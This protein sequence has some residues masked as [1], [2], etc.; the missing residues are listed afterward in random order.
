M[1]NLFFEALTKAKQE[2]RKSSARSA[3]PLLKIASMVV[4]LLMVSLNVWGYNIP[5]SHPTL[6]G[7]T[8]KAG[9]PTTVDSDASESTGSVTL[10]Y[11]ISS[12]YDPTD[13]TITWSTASR[14]NMTYGYN[15]ER[16]TDTEYSL[17]LY[18]SSGKWGSGT[19]TKFVNVY[20]SL[21]LLGA[22]EIDY[23][24]SGCT[25]SVE[26]PA[27]ALPGATV[28]MTVTPGDGCELS[29]IYALDGDADEITVT[30]SGT[31]W[32]FTMPNSEVTIEVQFTA[33]ASTH[34]ITYNH[35]KASCAQDGSGSWPADVSS[36]ADGASYN[37][38]PTDIE[39][40]GVD[41]YT[42][43]GW[44]T[45]SSTYVHGTS[46]LYTT[47]IAS[48]TSDMTLYPVFSSGSSTGSSTTFSRI[49]KTDV[50]AGY[51]IIS[52]GQNGDNVVGGTLTNNKLSNISITGGTGSSIPATDRLAMWQFEASG[53]SGNITYWTIKNR[54]TGQY[55]ALSHSGSTI[56]Q[57]KIA[58]QAAVDNYAKWTISQFNA[59]YHIISAADA[60]YYLRLNNG[61]WDAHSGGD[62]QPKFLYKYATDPGAASTTY[63]IT[64]EC[65]TYTLTYN[66]NGATSGSVP[67]V[68]TEYAA[69]TSV[70]VLGN[71]G[72]LTKT[73]YDFNGWKA[74]NAS[75][76]TAYAAGSSI[77]MSANHTLYAQWLAHTI[78]LTL[79]ANNGGATSDGSASVKYDA[80][81]LD[82]SPTL[83]SEPTG[84]TILGYYAAADGDKKV[85]NA[86][87][88]FAGSAV[89]DYI[90][91]S[92]WSRDVTPTELYA[93]W[94][95]NSYT[96]VFHKNDASA[97]GT[98]SD[99]VFTYGVAQSLTANNFELEEHSFEGWATTSDGEVVYGDEETVN[100]L[101]ATDGAT[102]DLY[103]VWSNKIYADYK[104]TCSDLSLDNAALNKVVWITT[105]AGQV[106]R[107]ANPVF[108]ISG[109]GLKPGAAITFTLG[110]NSANNTSD[111][112]SFRTK[113]YSSIAAHA[114][115]GALA[116]TE[117]YAFYNPTATTDGLDL[118][119]VG[120]QIVA[121]AAGGTSGG[122]KYMELTSTLANVAIN[123]RHLPSRFVIAAR[124]GKT[125]YAL[126]ANLT[127][128]ENP[129]PVM[130]GV[131]NSSAPTIAY[132][133]A[134]NAYDLYA[135][136]GTG[137]ANWKTNGHYINFGMPNN[138][139]L[140][141]AALWANNAKN[142]TNIGK[143]GDAVATSAAL[144]SNYFWL[145]EQTNNSASTIGEVKYQISNPNNSSPL[146]LNRGH[147][148]WGLY[149][150]TV[151]E[152]HLLSIQE[153]QPLTLDVME[154]G[155]NEM[156]V[157]YTG[158]GTL[159]KV[160]IGDEEEDGASMSDIAGD[161]KRI[162]G[163]NSMAAGAGGKQCQ[164]M[165]IQITESEVLKQKILQIPFIVTGQDV[166]TDNLRTWTDGATATEQDSITYNMEIVVRP[167]AKLTTNSGAG[168]FGKLSVYPGGAADISNAIRLAHFTM[169]GG[170]SWLG[171]EFAM[172]H[173]KVTGNVTGTGN[174]VNYDYYIDATKYYDLALPKTMT[175]G[176]VT[177]D[178]GY[179]NFTFWVKEYDGA[180]RA[181][182]GK[183]W[184]W[185][186][187]DR[188]A[189]LW[190]INAG[191][192]YLV[193]ATPRYGRPYLVMHF[194]MPLT[195][196]ADESS[197]DPVSV[198]AYG[199]TGGSLNPGVSANNAGWNF[200]AN[201]F[202]TSYMKDAD[203]VD[204]EGVAISG[205]IKT[206][207]LVPEEKDGKPTGK[208]VW[209]ETGGKKI[210]YVTTYDYSTEKYTQHA[211]SSTVLEP[212]TGFFI[213]VAE[214]CYVKFDPNERQNNIIARRQKSN[215]PDDM[216]V[217]ITASIGEQSDETIIL[218]CD[219]L[220][221]DNALEFPDESSKIMNAGQLNFYTFAGTNTMYANGMT[222]AEGQ[223]WNAAG[224]TA[225]VDGEY[226]FSAS[227]V[228]TEYVKAVMLKDMNTN[229]E[230]DLL[231]SDVTIYLEKGTIDGRFAI[232]IVLKSE[233]EV[234]TLL[235]QINED[236]INRGPEKFIYNDVMYIRHNGRIYDAT[237]RIVKDINK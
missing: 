68:A 25:G 101:T 72:E 151:N 89:A 47:S 80:T 139:T 188:D 110:G 60:S 160:Q 30:G 78:N 205:S 201:P 115:T 232:K 150:S 85:L 111:I 15:W 90:T 27:S 34:S 163:L 94:R 17:T 179:E 54:Y 53:S 67:A 221:R 196:A 135:I 103:A 228:N 208:Y 121:T 153:I 157:K 184:T 32:H 19:G 65:N 142:S 207:E 6:V 58:M 178:T 42:F 224:L 167:R 140:A 215:L 203:G 46:T 181:T 152:I 118:N 222:Y 87:G 75:S 161:L 225:T 119:A 107:S 56:N 48:V 122:K 197:K 126:P 158:G 189:S 82:A 61:V 120:T 177:D 102:I 64:P 71:S 186:N 234:T 171:S 129:D 3:H 172:P 147:W 199:M 169:R 144:G 227:K 223:E 12:G 128:T 23:S 130:I 146:G 137:I 176:P 16:I 236:G 49:T 79:Y 229:T 1:K 39:L 109:S 83:V 100:N 219:E 86:T 124:V 168:K 220:S 125:W 112:F 31:S 91:S 52:N 183:G 92:K 200:I 21:A 173:A 26:G 213:Q 74:D 40:N 28:N 77:T 35:T 43:V 131:D 37:S 195:L 165:L 41:G 20:L 127:N 62:E 55:M 132:T 29:T 180:T 170:Y 155:T 164:Q 4:L 96:V 148:K 10:Y 166:T 217:G 70:T 63:T 38:L 193:A 117:V 202:M 190:T 198:K 233:E 18:N 154:W 141:E 50:T 44:T 185:Y 93:H 187:W 8:Q 231:M 149:T 105:I 69:G 108:K 235:D 7:V 36:V 237:G 106:V 138:T 211:M 98:M 123:G 22:Y 133:D 88:T 192:G 81:A 76:G 230:Y 210:R 84:K 114:E 14:T 226:T 162:S 104:F 66:G 206:G 156:A 13:A 216:E 182:T 5:I 95:D 116:E 51:Y 191:Q 59:N 145:L 11:T 99:Q 159:T 218:L 57:N 73:G 24:T 113:D 2:R 214:D 97:T 209:D 136:A 45:E 33:A 143:S 9:N 174:V 175:W 212:F 134:S 194:P 204:G